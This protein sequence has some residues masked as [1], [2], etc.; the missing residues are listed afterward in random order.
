M[1]KKLILL[2]ILLLTTVSLSAGWFS[3]LFESSEDEITLTTVSSWKE[4]VNFAR[5]HLPQEGQLERKSDGFVYL[6]VD[7]EYINALYPMLG[8]EEKGYKKPPYFRR[9]DSPGA[10][11]S[12]FYADEHVHPV[13]IGQTFHFQ[14]KRIAIVHPSK[15]SSYVVLQVTSPE[16]EHLREE[17]GL[18]PKLKG[19]DFHISL[20]KKNHFRP[21]KKKFFP[22]S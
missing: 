3:R 5:V 17:Y 18:S 16:L 6:K 20:A 13:E 19:N 11:I 9:S 10:H 2:A 15:K 12:V 22:F 4:V 21:L 7:D 1:I 14:V 8:L